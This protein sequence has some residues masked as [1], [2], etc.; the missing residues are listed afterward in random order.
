MACGSVGAQRYIVEECLKSARQ[1]IAFSSVLIRCQRWA[2]QRQV[3]GKPLSSQA[4]I[5]SKLAAM[6]SRVE[7][8]QNW[9]ENITYQMNNMNY[10]QQAIHLAGY[11]TCFTAEKG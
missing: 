5:R 4:V 9:I 11:I 6:I 2:T 8:A 7:S 1:C 3:F 10:K